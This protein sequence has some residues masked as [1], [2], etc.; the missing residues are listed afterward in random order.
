MLWISIPQFCILHSLYTALHLYLFL[1]V[2]ITHL[3]FSVTNPVHLHNTNTMPPSQAFS[4]V[5]ISTKIPLHSHSLL[6]SLT[7]LWA[8]VDF[9]AVWHQVITS[10][11]P[12]VPQ[13]GTR[14]RQGCS[15]SLT[16]MKAS[17][18]WQLVSEL[19]GDSSGIDPV[20]TKGVYHAW[21]ESEC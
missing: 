2:P 9:I 1:S 14:L 20:L 15:A 17:P 11:L 10:M 13:S 5:W 6:G 18:I 16:V 4:S 3:H 12:Y 8:L 21:V 19:S 7:L